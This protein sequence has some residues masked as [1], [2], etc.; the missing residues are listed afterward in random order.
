[1]KE[2]SCKLLV[3]GAGPGGYVCAIRAA[4]LG[5]DTVIVEAAKPGGTCLNIGCIPSKALIHAADEFHRI[6]QIAAGTDPLGISL[7]TPPAI[8]LHKT[9]GWKNGIVG[10]LNTGVAGLLKKAGVKAVHGWAKFRDGRTVEV[11]TETGMQVIRADTIV[12]ATGSRPLGLPVLPFGGKVISSTEAL[13]LPNLPGSLAV[14]GG[15]YIG[16]E[17]GTAFAKLGT[18]VTVVEA[19]ERILP[20]YDGELTKPVSKRLETLGISV[21]TQAKA[22]GMSSNNDALL[23]ETADGTE[24]RIAADHVLVTVG[25]KP[26]TEGW[27]LEEIDLDRIGSFIRVDGQCRTSMRGVYAIGDVTGEPM[28]AHRAMAQGEMVAEIVAGNRRSW[29]KRAIPAV[30]FTDPEIVSVGLSPDEARGL[31]L[32]LKT[33]QFPLSANARTMTLQGEAGFV[34]VIARA[35]NHLLLGIQAVG[36]NVSELSAAFVLALEMG[37]RLED[38]AGTVH[39]HPTQSEGFQEAAL[40]ALGHALHI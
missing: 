14:V 19:Q 13:S 36:T 24:Q 39:A 25:R 18:K 17:L 6:A 22:K 38:I 40:K 31:G 11:E 20:L 15:G 8:D 16:L 27:G 12:I 37:A 3:I 2:I 23:V 32:E 29:D 4:Q 21:L 30:C 9:M 28:L 5:V 33:A 26:A 35:D 7:N 1:M 34:R 10:R